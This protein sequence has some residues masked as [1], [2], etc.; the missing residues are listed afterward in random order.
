MRDKIREIICEIMHGFPYKDLTDTQQ[1]YVNQ[2][3][4]KIYEITRLDEDKVWAL[5]AEKNECKPNKEDCSL[6]KCRRWANC[7]I[8]VEEIVS[9]Q[10]ELLK[11]RER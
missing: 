7:S 9:K 5:F 6:N 11:E 4:D 2:R 3:T 1:F 8:L 10:D